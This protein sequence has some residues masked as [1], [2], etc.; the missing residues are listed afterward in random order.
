MASTTSTAPIYSTSVPNEEIALFV[1]RLALVAGAKELRGRGRIFLA[2]TPSPIVRFEARVQGVLGV[3][4]FTVSFASSRRRASAKAYATHVQIGT[5]RGRLGSDVE[6]FFG[7][8]VSVG[9]GTRL[10]RVTFHVPNFPLPLAPQSTTAEGWRI[11]LKLA[12]PARIPSELGAG[13]FLITAVGQLSR[14]DGSTFSGRSAVDA[15]YLVGDFLSFAA[16]AWSD[17]G[18]LVGCDASGAVVWR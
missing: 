9:G 3:E 6:G 5:A 8:P 11:E 2:W 18:L 1:G 13:G 16:G 7:E 15:L 12:G 14:E 4:Q 10:T 17:P